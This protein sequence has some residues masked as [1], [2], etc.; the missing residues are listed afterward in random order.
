MKYIETQMKIIELVFNSRGISKEDRE[1]LSIDELLKMNQELN[2]E[3]FDFNE[4][5]TSDIDLVKLMENNFNEKKKIF[6]SKK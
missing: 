5:K 3:D 4:N 2:K 1:N 6:D